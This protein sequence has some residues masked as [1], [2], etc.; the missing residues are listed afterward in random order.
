MGHAVV[1]W[2]EHHARRSPGQPALLD[3]H[4]GQ[5][6]AY[7][8]LAGRVRSVAWALAMRHGIRQGD[9][10]AVL[11]RNDTR[12]FEVVYAC[13]LLGAIVVPLNWRLTPG[14]LIAVIH[15]AEP[16]MLLHESA[17]AEAASEVAAAGRVP[18]T[19][20]WASE[21]AEADGYE[22]LATATVPSTWAPAP[23][24]E[25]ATWMI[26]YTSGTTG[27]PKGVQATHRGVMASMQGILVAHRVGADS[28]CLTVLPTFHVAGLNLFAN[29]VLYMGGTVLVARTFDPAQTLGLLTNTATP[30]THFCG[31]PAN[32]QFMEQLP[33]FADA[34]LRPFVAVVGGSPVPSALVE[35]WGRRGVA[36]TTVFGITEAG[37]CVTAMPPGQELS[38]NGTVGTPLL[39]AR[40]R[41]RTADDRPS[42]PGETGELQVSGPLVTPG[43][44]R[45][46]A[47]TAEALTADGWLRTGDAAA[48]TDD[49][50]FVLVD[51]WKDM[52]ISGGENV[53][54]AE[55]EN[56]LHAHAAVSQAAVVGAP[57][58]RWGEAGVAFVVLARGAAA[59]PDG[60]R[61]W[62]RERLAAYKVPARVLLV[63]ELPRN[64]TGK[65][66][67]GPLREFA[68]DG[69]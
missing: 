22:V 2:L 5:A 66:L 11:S 44:W 14:E 15:D 16:A 52:Y 61:D 29:P 26:I 1:S 25:D 27:L 7:G 21:P 42:A 10:V 58:P 67:K 3:L 6:L 45:N 59:T 57:H 35:S 24:D 68:G 19:I 28:R 13:A 47:A 65:V 60:L 49:G 43:Y 41:V 20:A 18:A 33:G 50:H 55:V 63:E 23:V 56:A 38:H 32:Y 54:P 12:V 30:V 39:Y 40:C 51:R 46:P 9:R 36:L 53:Y 4:R 37:A 17:S 64:A 34:A 69:E 31:V 48:G 62:C 8:E